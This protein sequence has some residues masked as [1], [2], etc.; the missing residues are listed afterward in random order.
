MIESFDYDLIVIGAGPGGYVAAIRAS[1]LGMKTAIV[2]KDQLGGVCL[3]WGC[4]PS[5]SL[6]HQAK[7]FSLI[8]NLQ[9]MKITIDPSTFDYSI[10]QKNSRIVAKKLSKGV[11]YL[12]KKNAIAVINGTGFID[13][14][15]TVKVNSIDKITG[16]KILIATGSSPVDIP[17]FPCDEKK[18]LS[19][20]GFLNLTELPKSVVILGAGAIGIECAYILASFGVEVTIVEML[21][22]ILPF[23]D[24]E[25]VN[26][27]RKALRKKR[28]KIIINT[29]A[30]SYSYSDGKC[31]VKVSD[32]QGEKIIE[33]EKV[34]VAI[35]RKPNTESI[36]LDNIGIETEKGFIPVGDYYQT[37]VKNVY[38]IGDVVKTP[39]LAH[40]A[41][42]EGE[43]AVEHMADYKTNSTINLDL[44]PSIVYCEPQVAGFG[45]TEEMA[46]DRGFAFDKAVFP[47]R[48]IGKA[49]A[50]EEAEGMVKIIY[51]KTNKDILGGHIVGSEASELIHELLLAKKAKLRPEDIAEMIHAHPS[52]SEGIKEAASIIEGKAIHI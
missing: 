37:S 29:R 35:G 3:N 8:K 31:F 48:G 17:S 23:S 22:K 44:I 12:M 15:H 39:L 27:L 33:A 4:I 38:A 32:N 19:S 26:V 45:L 2:E 28:I 49:V 30:E 50:T 21:D 34:L 41:S 9:K 16:A 1:Q 7:S 24:Q 25:I 42:K 13:S 11:A 36:G 14:E 18:I 43:I 40:V 5:K 20:T 47:Y 6:I 46:T 52:L 51:D 10:V